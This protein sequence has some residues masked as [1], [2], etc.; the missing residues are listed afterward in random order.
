MSKQQDRCLTK[1]GSPPYGFRALSRASAFPD[2]TIQAALSPGK[3]PRR[4]AA[5]RSLLPAA[6]LIPWTR[7]PP[8]GHGAGGAPASGVLGPGDGSPRPGA[9]ERAVLQVALEA[10]SLPGASSARGRAAVGRVAG[11]PRA[12]STAAGRSKLTSPAGVRRR[13]AQPWQPHLATCSQRHTGRRPPFSRQP[14]SAGKRRSRS[15]VRAGERGALAQASPGLVGQQA[16]PPRR[17][18]LLSPHPKP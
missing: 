5:P 8:R 13:E 2:G 10:A 17:L 16:R 1:Q 15:E 4:V 6:P 18:R 7:A 11:L 12:V 3:G 14:C 9:R